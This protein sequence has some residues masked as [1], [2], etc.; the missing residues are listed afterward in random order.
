MEYKG[1]KF[2]TEFIDRRNDV[3]KRIDELKF[4]CSRFDDLEL[5]PRHE[6]GS[7]GNLSYRIENDKCRFMITCSGAVLAA[8]MDPDEFTSVENVDIDRSIIYARGIYEPS[9][10]SY[11]HYLIYKSRPELKAIF[12]GHNQDIIDSTDRLSLPCTK[13]YRDYGTLD[14]AESVIDILADHDFIIIK[15]HGFLALGETMQSA[16]DICL[17]ILKKTKEF[18]NEKS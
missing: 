13:V 7:Y 15:D 16:G 8:G 1:V 2:K 5:A 18:E 17:E 6:T 3:D 10:E 4:W 12:H 9:S 14:L 11:L